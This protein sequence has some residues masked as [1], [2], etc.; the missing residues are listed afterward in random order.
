MTRID[1]VPER[2]AG[3]IGRF[4]YALSRRRFGEVAEPLTVMAHHPRLLLGYGM[5]ELALERS[6]LVD[7]HLKSLAALKAATMVGCE[8]CID[9]GSALSRAEGVT[10]VQ[11]RELPTFERSEAFSYLEKL[12]LRYAAAVTRTPADIPD[13]PFDALREHF[14]EAQLVELTAA[15]ALENYRAWFNHAFGMGSQEFSEGSFCA[16]PE[17]LAAVTTS[18]GDQL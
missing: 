8:F 17:T 3:P 10:E 16:V 1:K 12:V 5:F 14:S 4:A 18:G 9:I 6:N 7:E 15:I 11:L 2:E 13:E